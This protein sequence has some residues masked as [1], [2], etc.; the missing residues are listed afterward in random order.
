MRFVERV[1]DVVVSAVAVVTMS[2]IQAAW[3][4]EK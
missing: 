3:D 1:V 4:C 2:F